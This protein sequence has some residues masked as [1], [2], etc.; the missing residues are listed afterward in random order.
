MKRFIKKLSESIDRM[1]EDVDDDEGDRQLII[2]LIN[3][4]KK[5]KESLAKANDIAKKLNGI[6]ADEVKQISALAKRSGDKKLSRMT[7]VD[8]MLK[9]LKSVKLSP[10]EDDED[11]D[12]VALPKDIMRLKDMDKRAAG[13][14]HKLIQLAMRMATAIDSTSKAM[15]RADAAEKVLSKEDAKIVSR[16]FRDRSKHTTNEAVDRK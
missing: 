12:N 14:T 11:G 2:D 6:I 4:I 3:E 5:N 8:E 15:R 7:D 13:N 16:I 1:I 10:G 9:H